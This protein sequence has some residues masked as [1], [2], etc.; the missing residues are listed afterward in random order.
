MKSKVYFSS[1]ITKESVVNFDETGSRV[2]GRTGW[3][4]CAVTSMYT[5]LGYS[6][7]RGAK[8]MN[9]F[10]V[11]PFY[12]GIIQ[13]D[14]WASYWKYD[15]T[16]AVCCAHLLRELNGI[17]ENHPEQVWAKHFKILLVNMKKTKDVSIMNGETQASS[18]YIGMYDKQYDE[19]LK[20][21]YETNPLL[22]ENKSGKRGRKKKGK[23]LLAKDEI[24]WKILSAN[25]VP[26]K[27]HEKYISSFKKLSDR[28]NKRIG[29]KLPRE[30]I[31]DDIKNNKDLLNRY[32]NDFNTGTLNANQYK[33]LKSFVNEGGTLVLGTGATGM[34]T[35]EVFKDNFLTGAAGKVETGL[36]SLGSENRQI[37]KDILN[38]TLDDGSVIYE[39]NG[40]ALMEKVNV[41]KGNIQLFT[42]DLGLSGSDW[43][44]MGKYILEKITGNLSQSK[45]L[46]LN[47]ETGGENNFYQL[48][49]C[50]EI[51]TTDNAPTVGKYAAALGIYL[52]FIG[53]ALYLV[54][55]KLDKRHLTWIVIPGLSVIFSLTIYFMGSDTRLSKPYAQY[56]T[57]AHISEGVESEEL[58]FSLTAPYNNAYEVTVPAEYDVTLPVMDYYY[59][60]YDYNK[61]SLE[62]DMSVGYGAEV[63]TLGIRNHGAFEPAY[64]SAH[65]VK[66]VEGG[67]ESNI[68]IK[69][70]NDGELTYTGSVTNHLG[71]D[72]ESAVLVVDSHYIILGDFKNGETKQ[73]ESSKAYVLNNQ[74]DIWNYNILD[75]IV[76]GDPWANGRDNEKLR[77]YYALEYKLNRDLQNLEKD[78][79]L[80]GFTEDSTNPVIEATGLKNAG[81]KVVTASVEVDRNIGDNQIYIPSLD[82]RSLLISGDYENLYRYIYSESVELE[83]HFEED[84]VIT[85]IGYPKN[86]NTENDAATVHRGDGY[87]GTIE[88]FNYETGEYEQIFESGKPDTLENVTPYLDEGNTMRL[89]FRVDEKARNYYSITMPLLTATKEEARKK[90]H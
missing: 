87:Y 70:L 14:C 22:E 75:L 36:I 58:T 84:E 37:E 9:E 66:N 85:S 30:A 35:L 33:A 26:N 61:G 1:K 83:V 72:L 16:H 20:S 79:Y 32:I 7:K 5:L 89:F 31:F 13:H 67:I 10:G 62:Y 86:G 76:G 44:T 25:K 27:K 4:H 8:G 24:I 54:L 42:F 74:D 11:L 49:N 52:L 64:F 88:A 2:N 56:I 40:M 60:N 63:T 77:K 53:P 46:Q 55:K 12:K 81:I 45:K 57:F 17:L 38:I 59:G 73:I 28:Y 39:E 29:K 18:H 6:Q 68:S 21:A 34:K 48:R 65:S 51:L 47:G 50:L 19:I 90:S 82:S 43:N 41:G 15:V 23:I 3:I 69:E 78:N 71:Y 80:L